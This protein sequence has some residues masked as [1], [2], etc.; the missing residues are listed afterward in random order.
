[1][2]EILNFFASAFEQYVLDTVKDIRVTD[3]LDIL[4]LSLILYYLYSFIRDRRAGKLAW[5]LVVIAVLFFL[6][7]IFN[8][9]ALKLIF[10]NFYQVG[11]IA[12][13]IVFQPELRAALEKVGG[14]SFTGLK[15]IAV[16]SSG[17]LA[18]LNAE[19]D[20]ICQSASDLSRDK[21]GALIVIERSTKLGEYIKSGVMV[22]SIISPFVLRNIFFDKA[23]LHDGATIIRDGRVHAA[24]CFLPLSTN[25]DIDKDLGTRHRAA[26]GITEISD[27]VVIVVS[28]ETGTISLACDGN[29][30]RNFNYTTLKQ[31]LNSLLVAPHQPEVLKK[32]R[33]KANKQ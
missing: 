17:K 33:R 18:S 25:D 32:H 5:G 27:A 3:I 23:P 8:M 29:L 1:M 10:E 9:Y 19:I 16:E 4:I 20:A 2:G 21:V 12:I 6:S 7:S 22:D 11:F 15:N 26:I 13:L 30:K 31:E 24:G 28:E 14:T